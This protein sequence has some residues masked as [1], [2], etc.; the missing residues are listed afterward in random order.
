[1]GNPYTGKYAVTFE[2]EITREIGAFILADYERY[3]DKNNI[4]TKDEE[5]SDVSLYWDLVRLHDKLFVCN[6]VAEVKEIRTA[7]EN[8]RQ[9]IKE[10]RKSAEVR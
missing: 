3:F 5:N 1:M 4:D 7:F 2:I 9:H 6:T 8:A 10:I